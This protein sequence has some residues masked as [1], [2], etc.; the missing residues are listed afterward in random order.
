MFLESQDV[1]FKEGEAKRTRSAPMED[2][3]QV[4]PFGDTKVMI[5]DPVNGA[6]DP[7][8]LE[9]NKPQTP[10]NALAPEPG[11]IIILE[12]PQPI[13]LAPVPPVPVQPV[14]TPPEPCQNREREAKDRGE[15]WANELPLD[16][17]PLA[18]IVQN[19]WAFA[20]TNSEF[21]VP[22]TYKQAMQHPNLWVKPMKVEYDLLLEKDVWELV[23]LPLGA[24]L[25]EDVGLKL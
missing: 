21:W 8:S 19:P 24:N 17:Q 9:T 5:R 6:T 11:P 25:M 1:R 12:V 4:L 15:A 20:S 2:T 7:S 10:S 16:Q 14:Q 3:D 13:P 23:E 22:Q 18:L